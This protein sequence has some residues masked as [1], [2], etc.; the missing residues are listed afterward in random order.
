MK[1]YFYAPNFFR[2]HIKICFKKKIL[3]VLLEML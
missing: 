3:Q 1:R 2:L